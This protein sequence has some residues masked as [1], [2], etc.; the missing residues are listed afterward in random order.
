[1]NR[2]FAKQLAKAT[3]PDGTVDMDVLGGLVVSAYEESERDRERTERSIQLMIAELDELNSRDR[4]Q[5]LARLKTQ[6]LRFESALEN[7]S[8]GLCM[9]DGQHN[10]IVCSR[11]YA[12]MYNLPA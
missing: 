12:E 6:N 8:Q 9:F 11:L 5:L 1:M 10:L 4:E 7:M 2:L 3:R